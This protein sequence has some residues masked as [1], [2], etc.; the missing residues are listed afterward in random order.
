MQSYVCYENTFLGKKEGV[1]DLIYI[2]SQ[3]ECF[4]YYYYYF[5][6]AIHLYSSY[7]LE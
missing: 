1:Y 6:I 2:P 4:F 3:I 7:A 5:F